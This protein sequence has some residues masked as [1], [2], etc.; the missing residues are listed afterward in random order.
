MDFPFAKESQLIFRFIARRSLKSKGNPLF[1]D[2]TLCC[3]S[4]SNQS[5]LSGVSS[6][7]LTFVFCADYYI[8]YEASVSKEATTLSSAV[9]NRSSFM[10]SLSFAYHMYG[11]AIGDLNVIIYH[12]ESQQRV[13]VWR[14]SGNQGNAWYRALIVLGN[15]NGS[16]QVEMTTSASSSSSRGDT[17]LDVITFTNCNPGKQYMS[18]N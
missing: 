15:Q 14:K 11:S 4:P 13:V 18:T 1:M 3:L 6:R 9:F 5:G 10:C 12:T 17:A 16:F 8:Y 7:L 2:R